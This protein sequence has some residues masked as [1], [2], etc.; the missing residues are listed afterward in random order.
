MVKWIVTY[1]GKMFGGFKHDWITVII[2][3]FIYGMSSFPLMVP[4]GNLFVKK[5]WKITMLLMGKSTN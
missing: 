1:D 4:S 5:L 3:H 2:F